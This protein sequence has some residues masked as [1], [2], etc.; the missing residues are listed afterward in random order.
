MIDSI[1]VALSGMRGHERGLN[2]ISSNISNINTPGF[3]GSTVSFT[4]VFTG[5]TLNSLPDGQFVG[6][7]GSGGGLDASHTLLDMHNVEAQQT[8]RGLDLALQGNGFFVVQDESGA[9]R[10]TRAGSFEFNT[11]GELVV[12]GQKTKVMSRTASGQLVPL[13]L[14][15][16]QTHPAKATT[17]VKFNQI[18][19]SGNTGGN[20]DPDRTIDSL[21][22]FDK[23]GGKHT[24]QVV[25]HRDTTIP[26]L[27]NWKV[28]VSEN[29]ADIGSGTLELFGNSPSPDSSPLRLTLALAGTDAAEIA[30]N[31]ED[32]QFGPFGTSAS[33][34]T[35]AVEKQDGFASGTIGTQTFDAKGVLKLTYTNG[36][37]A[38]GPR[39][40]LAQITDEAGLVE[41]GDA[42]FEYR[43]SQRVGLREADDDLKVQPQA[44]ELSNVDLTQEFSALILMQRGYQA[45]SQVVSTANDMLQ[46]LL[47]MRGGR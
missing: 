37:A 43:G 12:R 36:Q 8:G 45:S 47:Q 15:D 25:L 13:T 17:E 3:R 42:L 26:G 29:N 10:Y 20:A 16:L 22:V 38:D 41:L 14:K 28:T 6:Q 34:S 33:S 11:D 7:R 44:L 2:V 40:V 21:V 39:L 31:F 32:V 4:D 9:I 35:M 5:S 24:L 18:L 19:S 1:F 23:Q 27:V 30:F 46:E